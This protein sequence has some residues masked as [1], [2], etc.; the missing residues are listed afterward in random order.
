MNAD[1]IKPAVA[2][3]VRH[4][5]TW[6]SGLVAYVAAL[7]FFPPEDTAE[8]TAEGNKMLAALAAVLTVAITRLIL[9]AAAKIFSPGGELDGTSD[10][11]GWGPG[12]VVLLLTGCM[13][14]TLGLTNCSVI[15][16]A[17]TGAPIPS[18]GMIRAGSK[19]ADVV[20]VATIDL[21]KAEEQARSAD[22]PAVWGLYDAG[23]AAAELREVFTEGSK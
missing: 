15:G 3:L 13:F 7:P 20:Q 12:A 9:W 21:L 18:T 2:S 23:R 22:P 1:T 5:V 14:V 16:S 17:V 6:A 8:V 10:G 11:P 19:D 4:L